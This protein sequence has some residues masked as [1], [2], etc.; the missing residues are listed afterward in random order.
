M[1]Y[2]NYIFRSIFVIGTIAGTV[3]CSRESNVVLTPGIDSEGIPVAISLQS[4]NFASS[5]SLDY[6]V[7]IFS[8]SQ[9]EQAE[10]YTL[11][12][13]ISPIR[14]N[15]KL[16]FSNNDLYHKNYRFLFLATPSAL[17]ETGI[18]SSAEWSAPIPGTTWE[19]IRIV[20]KKSLLSTDNYY[21]VK[22]LSGKDILSTD[23]IQAHLTRF[24]GKMLFNFFKIDPTD[25]LPLLIEKTVTS[26]FDR[27]DTIQI[28]YTGYTSRLSF[29]E[30]GELIPDDTIR[31]PII[32][33]IYLTLNDRLDTPIPQAEA[34][35]LT[36]GARAGGQINGL[37][38][39]PV[40]E[41]LR[42]TLVF[43]YYDTTP[44]CGNP[45]HSHDRSCYV[46][47]T[48]ELQL[49][50]N[51]LPSALSIEPDTYTVNKAGIFCNRIID[52][53]ISGGYEI[54]TQWNTNP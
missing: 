40:T 19:N 42:A 34:D 15:S 53:G 24:V 13:L 35:T 52:I 41:N 23:T 49:P 25:H 20:A 6:S 18:V 54:D 51:S 1:K 36:G 44:K 33:K 28:T 29:H 22:D 32:Q 30:T 3:S 8:R 12:T 9:E 27:I 11:D 48:L 10:S 45:A 31:Q 2:F 43:H 50:P 26:I 14:E 4:K 37:Y 46:R 21:Q 16:K 39:L 38:F 47:K 17:E 5:P 7:Y